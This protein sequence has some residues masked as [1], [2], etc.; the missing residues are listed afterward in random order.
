[1]GISIPVRLGD[2]DFAAC[3]LKCYLAT[4]PATGRAATPAR[5]SSGSAEAG[6]GRTSL[7]SSPPRTCSP[8]P[9]SASGSRDTTHWRFSLPVQRAQ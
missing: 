4:N 6:T 9:C 1:M 5:I 3:L 8:S 2:E 7:T